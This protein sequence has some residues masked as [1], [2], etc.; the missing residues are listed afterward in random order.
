MMYGR[1]TIDGR[2]DD[3][4][5]D[6]RCEQEDGRFIA[7]LCH[8]RVESNAQ[9]DRANAIQYGHMRCFVQ[10]P[11]VAAIA[12][13]P[14]GPV[15]TNHF[16]TRTPNYARTEGTRAPNKT[17]RPPNK[18]ARDPHRPPRV[19]KSELRNTTSL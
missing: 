14:L 3:G 7:V 5:K 12:Y 4:R 2:M 16:D 11:A 8:A 6:G 10:V 15:R 13:V 19:F 1:A 18:L 17:N 9:R